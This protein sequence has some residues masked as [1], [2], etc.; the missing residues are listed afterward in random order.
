LI[1]A[2]DGKKAYILDVIDHGWDFDKGSKEFKEESLIK[3][4][5]KASH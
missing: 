1:T 4:F 2:T 5:I 3:E